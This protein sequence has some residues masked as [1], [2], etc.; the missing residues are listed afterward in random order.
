MSDHHKFYMRLPRN[1][2]EFPLFLLIVSLV[3]VNLIAPL[4]AMLSVGFSWETWRSVLT[5]LPILWPVV[6]VL[7]M[8]TNKPAR[9]LTNK[10]IAPADSF[11]A[12]IV[13]E[14]LCN[15]LLMSIILTV[16]GT[17]IGSRNVSWS[18]IEHFIY[19]WPRNFAIA[20]AVELLVAHPTAHLLMHHYHLR[21][22]GTVTSRF[23]KPQV[24]L[25]NSKR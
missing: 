5:V 23:I 3:S 18:P 22:D 11:N 20:F 10:I 8:L 9:W 2:R 25:Q 13:V 14:L 7:V 17:W 4:V 21:K 19:L 16:V 12:H 15:V 24:G 1:G 6:I